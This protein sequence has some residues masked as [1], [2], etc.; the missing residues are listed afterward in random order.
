MRQKIARRVKK[1]QEKKAKAEA[2]AKKKEAK[3]RKKSGTA[4]P[5]PDVADEE[6]E[7]EDE[8]DDDDDDDDG[9]DDDTDDDD[10]KIKLDPEEEGSRASW[11]LF[12]SGRKK[13]Q[14]VTGLP[15]FKKVI[16]KFTS[17]SFAEIAANPETDAITAENFPVQETDGQD[18]NRSTPVVDEPKHGD[19]ISWPSGALEEQ[20]FGEEEGME[21]GEENRFINDENFGK[22]QSTSKIFSKVRNGIK[23]KPLKIQL[24]TTRLS[25]EEE[26]EGINPLLGGVRIP[27][28]GMSEADAMGQQV[29]GYE[30]EYDE[31]GEYIGMMGYG[32][33]YEEDYSYEL[34]EDKARRKRKPSEIEDG[35]MSETPSPEPKRHHRKSRRHKSHRHRDEAVID[36]T[37]VGPQRAPPGFV[38]PDTGMEEGEIGAGEEAPQPLMNVNIPEYLQRPPPQLPGHHMQ[39]PPPHLSAMPPYPPQQFN[40][41]PPNVYP[42]YQPSPAI[43]PT[44][45]QW[46]PT[47]EQTPPIFDPYSVP[48]EGVHYDAYNRYPHPSTVAPP[49]APP[50]PVPIFHPDYGPSLPGPSSQTGIVKKEAPEETVDLA[51]ISPIMKFVAKKLE[52]R[53]AR[54]ELSG[55]FRYREDTPGLSK[56]LFVAFKMVKLLEKAGY[57]SSKMYMAAMFPAGMKDLRNDLNTLVF[58]GKLDPEII[59]SRLTKMAIRCIKC[60]ISYYTGKKDDMESSGGE[61]DSDNEGRSE[62]KMVTTSLADVIGRIKESKRD[63]DIRYMGHTDKDPLSRVINSPSPESAFVKNEEK[64][65]EYEHL[66]RKQKIEKQKTFTALKSHLFK[67][68]LSKGID[69]RLAESQA[70]DYIMCLVETD[71]SDVSIRN[72]V[73][74]YSGTVLPERST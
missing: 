16:P 4:E 46:P 11:K 69:R 50:P 32:E 3:K 40:A 65:N 53:G 61:D 52:E 15:P 25:T 20:D 49:P 28:E 36:L 58:R 10:E 55:P 14:P 48:P 21:Q 12:K 42:G 34:R 29:E 67:Q 1:Q 74:R 33:D 23:S 54:L 35:E 22:I 57:D 44:A 73:A 27:T 71:Y 7:E 43:Q 18:T 62:S 47:H 26:G 8:D 63:E 45:P 70:R 60:F 31:N 9:D 41:P 56:Y 68:F 6:E 5:E 72:T 24:K 51:D 2:K 19:D 64:D 66:D 38:D 17:T 37:N 13:S 59:G 30:Y 39:V